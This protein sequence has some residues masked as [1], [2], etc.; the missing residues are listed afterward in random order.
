MSC[1]TPDINP[2]EDISLNN[3]T[4]RQTLSSCVYYSYGLIS[5]V[6]HDI[7]GIGKDYK[8][9]GFTDDGFWLSALFAILFSLPSV[10]TTSLFLNK[11][12]VVK[13]KFVLSALT[14]LLLPLIFIV[15]HR[16][17]GILYNK[18]FSGNLNLESHFYVGHSL[19]I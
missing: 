11:Y 14:W 6:T 2:N 9:N 4:S 3:I 12:T 5:G 1:V 8:A 16:S 15:I 17:S 18:I 13:S 19:L 10:L 7:L